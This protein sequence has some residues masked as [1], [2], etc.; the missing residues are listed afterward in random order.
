MSVL[1]WF[2]ADWQRYNIRDIRLALPFAGR[3][4]EPH[5]PTWQMADR[6]VYSWTWDL[7]VVNMVIP[8]DYRWDGPSIP[9]GLE[10]LADPTTALIPSGAHDALY[11][12]QGGWRDLRVWDN[13]G[14]HTSEPLI[15][16]LTRGPIPFD[17][18]NPP[19]HERRRSRA[20][21]L[22]RAFL[23]A[24]G[25]SED[26]AHREYI[27]VRLGGAAAWASEEPK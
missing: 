21:A 25:A 2:A 5:T 19:S 16:F 20:D 23:L 11:E 14:A 6:Y 1:K 7:G 18:N 22:Y 3:L 26:E 9:D 15:D 8:K 17:G 10:G 13:V 12:A 27:A 24:C 4:L